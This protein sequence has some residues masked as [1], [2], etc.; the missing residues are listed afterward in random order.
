MKSPEHAL[1]QA[2]IRIHEDSV[3]KAF[4]DLVNRAEDEPAAREAF[5]EGWKALRS[6][7][8]LYP[9]SGGCA[10]AVFES[11]ARTARSLAAD[12]LPLG[13]GV[14]MHLYPLCALQCMPL[15]LLSFASFQ[16]AILLRTIRNRSLILANAGGERTRG[17]CHSLIAHRDAE[18]IRLD[19]TF[20]YMSLATVADIVLFKVP[21]ANTNR[22]VLCA[23]DLRV[24]DSVQHISVNIGP[25]S[26]S[27]NMRLSDTSSVTFAGH[28]VPHGRYLLVA[29]DA[30]LRTTS[31]YQRCWFHL[32]LGDLYLA[33]LER[34]HLAWSL[35]RSLELIMSLSELSH[36][37]DY[38]LRLLDELSSGSDIQ[39][40]KKATSAIKLRVSLMAQSTMASLRSR[41]DQTPAAAEQLRA[42][43]AELG[44]IRS[45]PTAD[46]VILRSIGALPQP[47]ATI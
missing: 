33:R 28:R 18:G 26:F 5:R 14:A 16:R 35:P 45:Q 23:A 36:L 11:A 15:P 44:Y 19:G 29:D 2:E 8:D 13:I 3:V 6:R 30:A 10:S 20:D 17:A 22:T 27:G 43:A 39:P 32:F 4:V 47:E 24:V 40:L 38:A 37:R 34:L 21:L 31:D 1:M 7:L 25:W 42:D 41:A 12:C 46:E 9:V